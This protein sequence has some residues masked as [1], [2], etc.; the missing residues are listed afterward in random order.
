MK[1]LN[2][3]LRLKTLKTQSR[4]MLVSP[5][6]LEGKYFHYIGADGVYYPCAFTRCY[7]GRNELKELLGQD[8]SVLKIKGQKRRSIF[9]SNA[10]EKL[11]FYHQS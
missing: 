7:A 11:I 10:W 9:V 6:C 8:F 3:L 4:N 5:K 2:R 1:I